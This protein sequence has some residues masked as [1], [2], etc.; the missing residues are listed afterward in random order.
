MLL[1]VVLE[2]SVS[3]EIKTNRFKYLVFLF[4]IKNLAS[5]WELN[6]I[7]IWWASYVLAHY[8]TVFKELEKKREVLSWQ[9]ADVIT[10]PNHNNPYKTPAIIL[11]W[12]SLPR[13]ALLAY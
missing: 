5:L 12:H 9:Q 1:R 6:S 13:F 11:C 8:A 3:K 7:T 10:I 2:G 4:E